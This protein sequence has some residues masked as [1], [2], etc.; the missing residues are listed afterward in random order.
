MG[1]L[2]IWQDWRKESNYGRDDLTTAGGGGGGGNEQTLQRTYKRGQFPPTDP[3]YIRQKP[4]VRDRLGRVIEQGSPVKSAPFQSRAT[5]QGPQVGESK[6]VLARNL[7]ESAAK[8]PSLSESN[9]KVYQD[10]I[11]RGG[12]GANI[13]QDLNWWQK[14]SGMFNSKFDMD[15]AMASWKEKGGFEGLMANPAFTMGLAFLQAG[16]EGKTLGAGALDNVMKAGGI[17]QHYKKIIEDRKQEPIQATAADISEVESLL[18]TINIKEGN[19]LENLVTKWKGGHPGAEWSAAV[20]E[21]AVKYQEKVAA[22]QRTHKDPDGK[23]KTIRQTDKIKIMQDLINSKEIQFDKGNILFAG[24]IKKKL[25]NMARGGP[26]QAGKPYVVGE[27]GPEVIIPRSDGNVLS[28]DDSQIYAMLLA[29]N[30]QL[31]KVSRARAERILR[32]RF[33]EYFE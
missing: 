15:S 17:S 9:N 33:P 19:W 4:E 5:G 25:P 21:I 28:N 22:W 11:M 31:Q 12:K 14:L 3:K 2:D 27:E 23:P 7:A 8:T 6:G 13:P 10:A 26:V 1:L 20:E 16:A 30:P 24:T 32:T 18:G 29:S